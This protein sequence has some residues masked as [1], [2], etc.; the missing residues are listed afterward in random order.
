MKADLRISVKD[1]RRSKTLK[2]Q[3]AQVNF[4]RCPQLFVRMNRQP[5]PNDGRPVSI[6]TPNEGTATEASVG[7]SENNLFSLWQRFVGQPV[8]EH[9]ND[10]VS[11]RAY[12]DVSRPLHDQSRSRAH[13]SPAVPAQVGVSRQDAKAWFRQG[14]VCPSRSHRSWRLGVRLPFRRTLGSRTQRSRVRHTAWLA[15]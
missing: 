3:L 13:F 2:V 6:H 14:A 4:A 5:W 8:A 11:E 1:Y 10:Q 9:F 12:S 15:I 7:K